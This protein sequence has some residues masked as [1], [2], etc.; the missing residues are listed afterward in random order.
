MDLLVHLSVRDTGC[1]M[2]EVT[3]ARAFEPFFT[4][5]KVGEGTGLGLSIAHG[6]VTE[7][8]GQ[9]TVE[10]RVGVGT[11]FNVYLPVRSND[12]ERHDRGAAEAA[13]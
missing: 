7:H 6:I 12:D 13:A 11:C 10:S 3:S 9:L 5:K 1:G 4:T 8:G 2:D